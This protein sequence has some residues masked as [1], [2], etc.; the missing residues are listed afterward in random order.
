M[1]RELSNEELSRLKNYVD[2]LFN[3]TMTWQNR[4]KYYEEYG[5]VLSILR[6]TSFNTGELNHT[7]TKEVE[8]GRGA[9]T[10]KEFN[11]PY[12]QSY[13]PVIK[14]EMIKVRSFITAQRELAKS[15]EE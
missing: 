6:P 11:E 7:F 10:E 1:K 3:N 2:F 9:K 12:I 4:E 14:S 5:Y 15:E 8:F 13:L